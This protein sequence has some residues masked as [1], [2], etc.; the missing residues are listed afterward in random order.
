MLFFA[1]SSFQPER[2]LIVW[3]S[4]NLG[5]ILH[6]Y[7]VFYHNPKLLQVLC[8]SSTINKLSKVFGFVPGLSLKIQSRQ[9]CSVQATNE[10]RLRI[11]LAKMVMMRQWCRIIKFSP[12]GLGVSNSSMHPR[13]GGLI[14]RKALLFW[15][16]VIRG[17]CLPI[18]GFGLRMRS[19]GLLRIGWSRI[20][21]L[22]AEHGV[23]LE[24]SCGD[25][26]G[27]SMVCELWIVGHKHPI[28]L[29]FC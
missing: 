13:R 5:Q 25:W 17:I 7:S 2:K 22:G 3:E 8:V 6:Q 16:L 11:C 12:A 1:K 24:V 4:S 20:V 15:L 23:A 9:I 10:D 27:S 14:L 18:A 26:Q 29:E 19:V 21:S 28:D